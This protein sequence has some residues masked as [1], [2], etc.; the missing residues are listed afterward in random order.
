MKFNQITLVQPFDVNPKGCASFSRFHQLPINSKL[1]QID[2]VS[3][4]SSSDIAKAIETKDDFVC[5]FQLPNRPP[6]LPDFVVLRSDDYK[7]RGGPN[8]LGFKNSDN[9]IPIPCTK[10]CRDTTNDKKGTKKRSNGYRVGCKIEAAVVAT[11]YKFQGDTTHRIISEVKGHA[12]TPGLW[13][14]LISRTKH[15]K[16]H[17]IPEGQMP[18]ATEIQSQRLDPLVIEAEIF[19]KIVK[20]KGSQTLRKW[21][22]QT[23]NNYG[24]PWSPEESAIANV[25]AMC[26]GNNMITFPEISKFLEDKIGPFD[27][28]ILI[29]TMEKMV[30]SHEVL[31]TE[32]PPFL[33]DQEMATLKGRNK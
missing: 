9:L 4:T 10:I 2:D 28:N 27:T 13:N 6:A 1:L 5:R 21:S 12:H 26:W 31:L 7:K 23:G 3:V 14:V 17:R 24:V 25:V 16:H 15:P 32:I 18:T 8:I 33:S 22:A 11:P 20:I 29:R 30:N 19:E